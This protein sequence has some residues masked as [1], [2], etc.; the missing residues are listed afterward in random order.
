MP[1]NHVAV[2]NR[3]QK[4]GAED[5][6]GPGPGADPEG[7]FAGSTP[8]PHYTDEMFGSHEVAQSA[9]IEGDPMAYSE[10]ALFTSPSWIALYRDG[11]LEEHA[12]V[13]DDRNFND[14]AYRKLLHKMVDAHCDEVAEL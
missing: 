5:P 6:A 14:D 8:P 2:A 12:V 3:C 13:G 4:C 10:W 9:L 7:G 1:C 11:S